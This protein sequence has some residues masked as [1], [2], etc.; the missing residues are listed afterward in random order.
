MPKDQPP[1]NQGVVCRIE[2]RPDGRVR[3]VM[4]DV[5]HDS[6]A[7]PGTWKTRVLF[8]WREYDEGL[9][10]ESE[11]SESELSDVGLSVVSR[12]AAFVR[13]ERNRR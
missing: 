12:L 13:V 7:G 8:T 5:D 10:L 2:G 1:F 4:D 6:S 3:L 9:F 11:L